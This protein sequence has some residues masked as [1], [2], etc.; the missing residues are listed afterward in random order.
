MREL[1]NLKANVDTLLVICNEKLSEIHG[2]L[3]LTEAFGHADN[4]LA[5]AAKSIAEI[6][7]S[8]MHINVD[9]ADIQTVMKVKRCCHHGISEC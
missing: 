8:T 1:K 4:I 3:K 5:V 7:T 2:N 9:F 6:I